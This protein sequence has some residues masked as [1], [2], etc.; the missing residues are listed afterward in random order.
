MTT[1]WVTLKLKIPSLLRNTSV[2]MGGGEGGGALATD[3]L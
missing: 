1:L 3:I 2:A